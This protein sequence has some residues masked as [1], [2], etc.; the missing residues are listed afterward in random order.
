MSLEE[1]FDTSAFVVLSSIFF[2]MAPMNSPQVFG[3][4]HSCRCPLPPPSPPAVSPQEV[5]TVPAQ[6]KIARR[7]A[8]WHPASLPATGRGAGR[9]A[10]GIGCGRTSVFSFFRRGRFSSPNVP[11]P[12]ENDPEKDLRFETCK[13]SSSVFLPP[14]A[15]APVVAVAVVVAPAPAVAVAVDVAGVA[16]AVAAVAPAVAASAGTRLVPNGD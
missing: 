12:F 2:Q 9:G 7:S 11:A 13:P 8:D 14:A 16:A 5:P 1:I 15:A 6:E 3:K 10:E 4:R